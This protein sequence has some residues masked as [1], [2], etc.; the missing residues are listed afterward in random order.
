MLVCC[1]VIAVLI[2]QD[3]SSNV[4]DYLEFELIAVLTAAFC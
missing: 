3:I 4:Y 2:T 1:P